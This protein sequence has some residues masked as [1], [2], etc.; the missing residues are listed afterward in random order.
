MALRSSE[1]PVTTLHPQ[2]AGEADAGALGDPGRHGAS[3]RDALLEHPVLVFRGQS[4]GPAELVEIGL[5]FGESRRLVGGH[6]LPGF[7]AVS[8][9]SNQASGYAVAPYWHTDGSL[10]PDGA[11]LTLFH[12]VEAPSSGGETLFLDAR[13]A[14]DDL[15][16]ADRELMSDRDA[17]MVNR[18]PR[19]LVR[20]HPR[21]GRTA[22]WIDMARVAGIEGL[23]RPEAAAT[24]RRI[25]DHY[26]SQPRYVHAYRPGDLV[27]W[28]NDSVAHSATP[29]PPESER[30]V[31]L[32]LKVAAAPA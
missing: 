24:L 18:A 1:L 31:M 13:R 5:A 21:T 7:P 27:I 20:R 10:D 19:P 2:L 8:E 14:F 25:R 26:D 12:A 32:H 17:L 30:R 4:L 16:G 11:A 6:G 9:V 28:D 3:V 15:P 29:P 23:D 22:L